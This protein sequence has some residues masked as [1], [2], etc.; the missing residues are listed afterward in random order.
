V[1]HLAIGLNYFRS[2]LLT[3][4]TGKPPIFFCILFHYS[5]LPD[6]GPHIDLPMKSSFYVYALTD[7]EVLKF[8]VDS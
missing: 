6:F 3:V 1:K 8:L 7:H 5:F 2:V 4:D